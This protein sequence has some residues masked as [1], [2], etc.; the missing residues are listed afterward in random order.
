MRLSYCYSMFCEFC[1]SRSP[2]KTNRLSEKRKQSKEPKITQGTHD[3][4]KTASTLLENLNALRKTFYAAFRS[5][6][7]SFL[8]VLLDY[9]GEIE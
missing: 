9:S 3:K 1:A 5:E 8:S 6:G 7:I 2:N 4:F